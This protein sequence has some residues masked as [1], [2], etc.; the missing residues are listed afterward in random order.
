MKR[1]ATFADKRRWRFGEDKNRVWRLQ[2]KAGGSRGQG[3]SGTGYWWGPEITFLLNS[4]FWFFIIISTLKIKYK[5]KIGG[6]FPHNLILEVNI[7]LNLDSSEFGRFPI[8]KLKTT[9]TQNKR[10]YLLETLMKKKPFLSLYLISE[11]IKRCQFF[12][13][14]EDCFCPKTLS[15]SLQIHQ[16]QTAVQAAVFRTWMSCVREKRIPEV[17]NL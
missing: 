14:G 12:I 3:S 5:R 16:H 15:K 10:F 2:C 13:D 17:N 8:W 7:L 9:S 11:D 6:K 1:R 4:A